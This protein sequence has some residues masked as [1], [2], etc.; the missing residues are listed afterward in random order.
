[1]FTIEQIRE[2]HSK[3]K[4]GADFPT[5]IQALKALGVD[6]YRT[7]VNDGHTVY[8]GSGH[9][10]AS[11][12][13]LEVLT[14]AEQCHAEKFKEELKAHQ[15]GLTSYMAFCNACA[16]TGIADW[17]VSISGMTCT[18]HDTPGRT[19]LTEAIPYPHQ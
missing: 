3:V 4:T 2:A 9:T 13:R 16:D 1:M 10:A 11:E 7:H 19:V 6:T 15:Q 17:E 18:Y 12:A 5:Y 14:I 8:T